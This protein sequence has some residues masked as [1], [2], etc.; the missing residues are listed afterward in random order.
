LYPDEGLGGVRIGICNDTPS[1]LAWLTHLWSLRGDP[2]KGTKRSSL[3]FLDLLVQFDLV[4]FDLIVLTPKIEMHLVDSLPIKGIFCCGNITDGRES[5]NPRYETEATVGQETRN[6]YND[7]RGS[8]FQTKMPNGQS[9]SLFLFHGKLQL[10][11]Y[12][13]LTHFGKL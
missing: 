11:F 6:E 8:H 7:S 10:G 1:T 3:K 12:C 2:T 5:R 9:S 4:Q 13:A